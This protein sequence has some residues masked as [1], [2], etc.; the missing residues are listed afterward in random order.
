MSL[1]PPCPS[2]GS[3]QVVKNGS[4]HNGKSKHLC[5]NCGRQFVENATNKIV[6]FEE[7]E[8]IDK[9]LLERIS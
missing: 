8:L 2:C 4:I 9:R 3:T 7:R 5:R 1:K 6:T